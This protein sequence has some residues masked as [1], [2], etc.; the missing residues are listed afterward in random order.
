MMKRSFIAVIILLL[1]FV[2]FGQNQ[3]AP[4]YYTV[5]SGDLGLSQIARDN[6]VKLDALYS[7]NNLTEI[8]I[9]QIGQKIIVGWED[10][11]SEEI[12][13]DSA[14]SEQSNE[15]QSVSASSAEEQSQKKAE[16]SDNKKHKKE[17]GKAPNSQEPKNNHFSWSTLLVGLI[18]GIVLGIL[19]LC[20]FFVKKLK[21]KHERDERDLSQRIAELRDEKTQLDAEVLRLQSKI[22]SIEKEKQQFLDENVVLGEEIDRLKVT[23]HEKG[24][25]KAEQTKTVSAQIS[26]AP[27][28]LYADA[29]IDGYFVKVRET[30]DEDSVFVLQLNGENSAVFSVFESAKQRVMANPS[31]LEG[32]EKQILG[33]TMELEIMSKGLAQRDAS[34][35]KWKVIDK[36]NVI[37]R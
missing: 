23:G 14:A 21:A 1:P 9:I 32:C 25:N 6:N 31:Y 29:I 26:I 15:Q 5:K 19:L 20:F 10:V 12:E 8:S 33:N 28:A 27:T 16:T 3:R 30:L 37:I 4:K 18:L 7:W 13:G 22:R 24:E 36:L 2:L 11:P 35:G 17:R 34:N